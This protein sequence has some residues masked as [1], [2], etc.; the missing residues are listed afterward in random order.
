MGRRA[1]DV[2]GSG[3]IVSSHM[4][5]L[6]SEGVLELRY[7]TV[8]ALIMLLSF[9]LGSLVKGCTLIGGGFSARGA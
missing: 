8:N 4:T 6:Y 1:I 7:S 2:F 5:V 9:A 3:L